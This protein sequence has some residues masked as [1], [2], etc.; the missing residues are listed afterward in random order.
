MWDFLFFK[1]L[2]DVAV[3]SNG[4]FVFLGHGTIAVHIYLFPL[5]HKNI[6]KLPMHPSYPLHN[7][8]HYFFHD[9]IMII[10]I[11]NNDRC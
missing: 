8:T 10:I 6:L 7:S 2:P 9:K 5:L 3:V 11:I 1:G 4:H